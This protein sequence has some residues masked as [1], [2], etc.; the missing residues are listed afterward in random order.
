MELSREGGFQ[1]AANAL[2]EWSIV[3][4]AVAEKYLHGAST[5]WKYS[6]LHSPSPRGRKPLAGPE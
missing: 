6:A 2:N 3:I 4:V 1:I 5:H